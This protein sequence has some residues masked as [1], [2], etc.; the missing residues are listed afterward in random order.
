ML[1]WMGVT[2]IWIGT[3]FAIGS[4]VIAAPAEAQLVPVGAQTKIN[5]T[6]V[7]RQQVC[8]FAYSGNGDFFVAAWESQGGQDG[9]GSGVF[10]RFGTALAEV[11]VN[12]TSLGWQGSPDV[13][14]AQA[15]RTVVV[16]AGDDPDDDSI[17]ARIF[18]PDGTPVTNEL[19]VEAG[20]G[21][22][23]QP[24]VAHFPGGNF[25][26]V[27]ENTTSDQLLMRAFD[28][29]GNPLT[30]RQV[31]SGDWM[32]SSVDIGVSPD[33]FGVVTWKNNSSSP[34][35]GYRMVDDTGQWL[36]A[37]FQANHSIGDSYQAP[38]A[39]GTTG[40]V[41]LAWSRRNSD[42]TSTILCRA[43]DAAG[44]P[45]GGES[46]IA[47]LPVTN[48]YG[49]A[50]SHDEAGLGAIAWDRTD[51][52]DGDVWIQSL[53]DTSP[54]GSPVVVNPDRDSRHRGASVDLDQD[55]IVTVAWYEEGFPQDCYRQNFEINTSTSVEA[56]ATRASFE[57]KALP[58]IFRYET[59]AELSLP[60]GGVAHTRIFDSMGRVV[61]RFGSRRSGSGQL[62]IRWDGQDDRGRS[63]PAGTY[64][65]NS[66]SGGETATARVVLVR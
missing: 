49:L 35:V 17:F 41:H 52:S 25:I 16:W 51:E 38:E 60:S 9:S 66:R 15:G 58:T 22:A 37:G 18:Q 2:Q 27:W 24:R 65:I 7:D 26:V 6:T 20:L 10:A 3:L 14:M 33:G 13:S 55:G 4:V 47:Q 59:V 56:G 63:L 44:T 34:Y 31:V 23:Q 48:V 5:I 19:S 1:K 28:R 11:Q 62:D 54:T 36:S 29:F 21:Q 12:Q 45:L 32:D 57:L 53:Q 64:W 46:T 61:R 39:S 40:A 43:F 42:G 8:E 50:M 30:S